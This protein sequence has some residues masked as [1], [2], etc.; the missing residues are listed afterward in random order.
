MKVTIWLSPKIYIKNTLLSYISYS[1]V[2]VLNFDT[3]KGGVLP[4]LC[5]AFTS[6]FNQM[7]LL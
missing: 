5:R 1:K 2:L 3:L 7:D 6:K 4:S